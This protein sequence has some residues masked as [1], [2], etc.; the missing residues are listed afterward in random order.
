MVNDEFAAIVHGEYRRREI[1]E[2]VA[3]HSTTPRHAITIGA[4]CA[5]ALTALA[6]RITGQAPRVVL[7]VRKP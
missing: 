1:Q 3:Q 2:A 5:Q 4:R 6:H 7:N